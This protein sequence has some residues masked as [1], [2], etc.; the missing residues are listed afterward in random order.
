M[1]TFLPIATDRLVLRPF[2]G[3][4]AAV[5]AA[6][7]S[8]PDV[9]RYQSWTAPYGVG[10]ARTLIDAQSL[11]D[12]PTRGEWIQIAIE[13]DGELVGDVAVG[14]SDDG[15]TATIGYTV[16]PAHQGGGLATEAVG[17]VVARLFHEFA[18]HRVQAS[19]DPRNDASARVVERLGF[20]HEGT[21]LASVQHHG[22]W[23]DDARYALTADGHQAWWSRSTGPPVDVRLVEVS[24]T[25]VHDVLQLSTHP[26]QRHFV[27]PMAA[28]FADAF[29]PEWIDGAPVVPWAR[30]IDADGELVGFMM[31]AA[32]TEAHP[33]A[34]LWRL[35]I[36]RRHQ[37]RGI[38][39]RALKLL[40]EQLR[41]DGHQTLL[42]S[43]NPGVGGPGPLY[44]R[45]GF[46]PT[47]ELHNDEVVA[48]LQLNGV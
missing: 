1:V 37:R 47:G 40:F 33:E 32:R 39:T 17:A 38:G 14:L 6:Y 27:A 12:G 21:A 19:I 35:L 11:L 7:R 42:V 10:A 20:V 25:N 8:D 2:R 18:V 34:F 13:R 16:A 26:T 48:R 41:A 9:A 46:V 43:W 4:D 31:L 24:A 30:A 22:D 3:D 5:L 15:L 23:A 36:D 28:S 45:L 44:E 29:A